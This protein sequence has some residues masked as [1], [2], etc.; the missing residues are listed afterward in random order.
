MTDSIDQLKHDSRSTSDIGKLRYDEGNLR[1]HTDRNLDVISESIRQFGA[2][3][4]IVVDEDGTVLAGN[5]VLEAARE[6]GITKVR[7]VP[8]DGEEIVAVQ[9]S[10]LTPEQKRLYAVADNRASELSEWDTEALG[11]A[12]AS[13]LDVTDMFYE[14]ELF[15]LIGDGFLTEEQEEQHRVVAERAE[16]I[17]DLRKQESN[18]IACP[19]CYHEWQ[20]EEA[21]EEK[22]SNQG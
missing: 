18:L 22:T 7:L 11:R 8:V 13:G 15:K 19:H 2:A 5:G 21:H 17:A 12:I 10:H 14:E 9:V 6:N 20:W 1:R 16:A 4:A 3:R